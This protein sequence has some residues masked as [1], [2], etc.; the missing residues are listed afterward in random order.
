VASEPRYG[1]DK[2]GRHLRSGFRHVADAHRRL[3]TAHRQL[4]DA[5]GERRNECIACDVEREHGPL[6][7]KG[8]G[9]G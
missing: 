9:D 5:E 6:A 4:A 1:D 7:E 3:A 2:A 8:Q